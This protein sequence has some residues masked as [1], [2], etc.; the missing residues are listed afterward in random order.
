MSNTIIC[1]F[2]SVLGLRAMWAVDTALIELTDNMAIPEFHLF[3]LTQL[4]AREWE[5]QVIKKVGPTLFDYTTG[6]DSRKMCLP[7]L[8]DGRLY[9]VYQL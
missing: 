5:K 2:L 6:A 8:L 1:M 7:G 4:S 3:M 9:L